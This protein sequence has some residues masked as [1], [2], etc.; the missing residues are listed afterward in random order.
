V[1]RTNTA[2]AISAPLN[3]RTQ[4]GFDLVNGTSTVNLHTASLGDE[5]YRISTPDNSNVVPQAT[6]TGDRIQ[7]FLARS[8]KQGAGAVD[9]ALNSDVRWDLRVTGGV[10]HSVIDMSDSKLNA[11]DL[12]GGAT[13]IDLTL[14]RPDGTLKVRMTGGVNQFLVHT[15]DPVPVRVRVGSGAGQVKLDGRTHNGIPPGALFTPPQWAQGGDRIDL[16]AV[17]GMA[18]LTVD[19]R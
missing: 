13:R 2:N 19:Q 18:T 7:L 14:P 17:A 15:A 1:E 8:G 12:A 9:I 16:D 6:E 10:D 5:L 4:A 11:V 3:G